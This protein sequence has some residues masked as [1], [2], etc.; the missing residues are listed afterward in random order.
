MAARILALDADDTVVRDAG[1]IAGLNLRGDASLSFHS[2]M[3]LM[4]LVCLPTPL[5]AVYF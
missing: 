4:K 3:N 2:G 1:P 5:G